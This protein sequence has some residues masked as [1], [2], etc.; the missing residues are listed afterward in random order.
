MQFGLIEAVR[1]WAKYRGTKAALISNGHLTT[2]RDLFLGAERVAQALRAHGGDGRVAVAAQNKAA[3]MMMLLGVMRAGRSAV[4]LN[5]RLDGEALSVT[6]ADTTPN[7]LIRDRD[8]AN[9]WSPTAFTNIPRVNVDG[10]QGDVPI[11]VPW[12]KYSSSSEW[13][14][15]FSSGSTGVP[16]GIE[17]DHNSMITEIIGW[18]LE[19]PLTKHS[20]FYIGRPLFYTGG[21]VLSLASFFVGAT[22]IANDY[23]NDDDP[24]QVWSDY[25]EVLSAQAIEWAFFM[26]DQLR[27]FVAMKPTDPGHS[28]FILVM[29]APISGSE[30]V[31]ARRALGSQI[32]ESW[33][34]SESLGTITEP[35]DL[36]LRPDSVGRPFLTDELCVVDDSLNPCKPG[37]IG[38][39]A[40][41]DTAGFQEYSN[42]P[43][44]TKQ[45]KQQDLI[46][47]DDVGY[48]DGDGY[49]YVSGRV[50]DWVVRGDTSVFLPAIA[51]KI[52]TQTDIVAVEVCPIEVEGEVLLCAAVVLNPGATTTEEEV[53]FNINACLDPQEHLSRVRVLDVLPTLASGKVDRLA[54][55]SLLEERR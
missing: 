48:T 54:V 36:D 12:P 3:F 31:G 9:N 28:K 33:G 15:L 22:V 41:A 45:V 10:F 49:F 51:A 18:C 25:Q 34:N 37:E 24:A 30:K 4:V 21:L 14:V 52:R 32:V 1:H 47:S 23:R 50:Q 13:G 20:V 17:R 11:D 40:G 16:K 44:E 53:C 35:E 2:Y 6:V 19:L 38:R 29:G 43:D 39:I 46:I 55:C 27:T 5:T 8:L 26:P 7:V 42:R